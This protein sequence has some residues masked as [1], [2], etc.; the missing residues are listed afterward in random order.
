MVG[1][2]SAAIP[3]DVQTVSEF[4][5]EP[6]DLRHTF[7][8][9][10]RISG[11]RYRVWIPNHTV[12]ARVNAFVP[13][14]RTIRLSGKATLPGIPSSQVYPRCCVLASTGIVIQRSEIGF[15]HGLVVISILQAL[16]HAAPFTSHSSHD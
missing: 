13:T 8:L 3:N 15:A 7:L 4:N 16:H 10:S 9:A 6:S 12:S 14:P 1:S 5:D 11:I 2:R